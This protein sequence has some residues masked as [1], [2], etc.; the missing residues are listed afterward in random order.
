[1]HSPT[2]EQ[3]PEPPTARRNT[4]ILALSQALYTLSISVD[5]TLTGLVGYRLAADK[6]L[7]TLPFALITVA[8]A[9][10]APGVSAL[11]KRAGHRR[12]FALGALAGALGGL[13]SMRAIAAHAFWWFCAGTTAVGVSQAFARHYRLAAADAVAPAHKGR[14]ISTV[15]AG[16]VLAAVAGP[17]LASHAGDWLPIKTPFEAAYA[18]VAVFGALSVTVLGL[19]LRDIADQPGAADSAPSPPARPL[20][21][22][23]RQPAM[24]VA[25]AGNITGYGVMM[26]IMT[27]TPLAAIGARHTIDQGAGI[28]QWHLIGM[29]APSFFTGR[30]IGRFGVG[31]VLVAGVALSLC[32]AAIAMVSPALTHFYAALLCLGIGWNF[33]FVAGSTLLAHSYRPGERAKTTAVSEFA[34]FSVTALASLAAGAWVQRYGWV[35][36]NAATVPALVL[37]GTLTVWWMARSRRILDMDAAAGAYGHRDDTPPGE[38]RVEHG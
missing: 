8:A 5:L 16:G 13:I 17:V 31:A 14:A 25:L 2:S 35:V 38:R 4:R 6:T 28:I 37:T 27:A 24:A 18:L 29:Y 32:S 34:T 23:L 9:L 21:A 20:V 22:V 30:L 36:T 3:A 12:G 19:L 11:L 33:M 7:S 1:M 26:F 15:M 10:A